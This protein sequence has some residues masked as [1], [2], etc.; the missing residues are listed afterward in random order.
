MLYPQLKSRRGRRK[1]VAT[2]GHACPNPNCRYFNNPDPAV[3]ALVGDGHHGCQDRSQDFYCQGCHRK[4]TARRQ[5][6]LY[7]L[8]S[9]PA[10][11][12]QVLHALAAGLSLPAAVRV[13][14]LSDCGSTSGSPGPDCMPEVAVTPRAI[15]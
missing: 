4:F 11:A 9:P 2:Q 13:F 15:V 6:V 7:R 14:E 8:K 3:H 1:T 10:L 5:T 12:A